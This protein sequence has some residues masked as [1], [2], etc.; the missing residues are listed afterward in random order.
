MLIGGGQPAFLVAL[1][2]LQAQGRFPLERLVRSYDFADVNQA[3]DDSESGE[4]V[5]PILK[6]A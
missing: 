6:M 4:V 5:K 3:I 1:M 2:Q